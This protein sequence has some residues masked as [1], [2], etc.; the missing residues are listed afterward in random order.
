MFLAL[1]TLHVFVDASGI[2][3]RDRSTYHPNAVCQ[4][5][6]FFDVTRVVADV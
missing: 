2:E 6:H 3:V 5:R 4:S 1:T